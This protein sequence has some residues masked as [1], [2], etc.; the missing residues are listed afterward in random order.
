MPPSHYAESS[1]SHTNILGKNCVANTRGCD[2]ATASSS[3]G[4]LMP[5]WL[6]RFSSD[7][8]ATAQQH[9]I[10][11][12]NHTEVVC[13]SIPFQTLMHFYCDLDTGRHNWKLTSETKNHP[14][15]VVVLRSKLT[16]YG[17]QNYHVCGELRAVHMGFIRSYDQH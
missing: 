5:T 13:Q 12:A 1:Q 15:V 3:D 2:I 4:Q 17:T 11:L 8:F 9:H 14:F 7:T 16:C 6:D 10:S